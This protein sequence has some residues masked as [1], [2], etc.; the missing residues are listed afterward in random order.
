[1]DRRLYLPEQWFSAEYAER[2][3]R[4]GI[5][6]GVAFQSK[7]ELALAMVERQVHLGLVPYRWLVFDEFFGRDGAFLEAVGACG[8]YLAEVP[9]D[10]RV[11]LE[12]PRPGVPAWS[13]RGRKPSKA[14]VLAKDAQ[15]VAELAASLPCEGWQ[16]FT[17]KEEKGPIVA[18]LACL[19][20]L[21]VRQQGEALAVH[22]RWLVLRREVDSGEV[23]Y[24][25][26]N[27]PKDTA[28]ESFAR[29]SVM[30]SPIE[31]C[32]Q[33]GKQELGMGDYQVRSYLGWHHH[34][35]LVILAH[36]F[37]VRLKLRLAE[38]APKLTLPQAVMLLK[39]SLPQAEFDLDKAIRVVNYYQ[40]R[41]E[42]ARQSHR[43]KRL[44]RLGRWFE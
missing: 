20:V 41:H 10:S 14:R 28:L 43:K 26:S 13:G 6:A 11:Y 42:A 35:T 2:R 3:E 25:L 37:L 21:V 32:F 18:H 27:A 5:P 30:R 38:R 8:W 9:N 1:M 4:C 34:M 24:Y 44:A 15:P 36:F 19:R 33:E 16:R 23:K 40:E 17:L 39:A 31:S 29:L 22:E 7:S 12:A